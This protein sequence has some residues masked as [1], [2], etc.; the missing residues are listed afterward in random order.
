M[1]FGHASGYGADA[2]FGDELDRNARFGVHILE[3]VD[4]LREIFDEVQCRDAAEA[5]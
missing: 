1:G 2:D 5:R 3:V 4:E